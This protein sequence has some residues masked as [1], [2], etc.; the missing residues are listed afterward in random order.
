MNY[1]KINID[2]NK[3]VIVEEGRDYKQPLKEAV[4]FAFDTETLV[5]L[6][7]KIETQEIIL[8]S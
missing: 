7:G 5:Y 8:K 2:S 6:D 3:W 4:T 1:T